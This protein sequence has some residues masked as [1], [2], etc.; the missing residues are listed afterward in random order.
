MQ[1]TEVREKEKE[2]NVPSVGVW[3]EGASLEDQPS[4]E[5][6]LPEEEQRSVMRPTIVKWKKG[7]SS[8][9]DMVQSYGEQNG[10]P[11]LSSFRPF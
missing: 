10:D 8:L 4:V 1:K 6:T 11:V 9:G 2:T 7:K 3:L 5:E